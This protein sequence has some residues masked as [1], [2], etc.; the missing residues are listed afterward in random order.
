MSFYIHRKDRREVKK[1]A[2]EM[3]SNKGTTLTTSENFNKA[4]GSGERRRRRKWRNEKGEEERKGNTRRE[5]GRRLG[6]RNYLMELEDERRG[7][8][9]KTSK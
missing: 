4:K 2:P 6:Q 8:K 9:M 1:E 5:E 7:R 3:K